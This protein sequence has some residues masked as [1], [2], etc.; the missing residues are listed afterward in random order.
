MQEVH[1]AL[2]MG[3]GRENEALVVLQGIEPGTDIGG[4]IVADFRGDAEVGAQ[5]GNQLFLGI[6]FV[7]PLLAAEVAVEP[8]RVAWVISWARVA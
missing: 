4:V 8:G 3:G 1:G 5:L 6:A 7:A 2:R